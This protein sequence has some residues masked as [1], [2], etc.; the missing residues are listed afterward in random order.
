MELEHNVFYRTHA[1]RLTLHLADL[2]LEIYDLVDRTL[3]QEVDLASVVGAQAVVAGG[4]SRVS[5][6]SSVPHATLKIYNYCYDTGSSLLGSLT[7]GTSLARKYRSCHELIV[8]FQDAALCEAWAAAVNR[9]AWSPTPTPAP[10][11]LPPPRRRNFLVF[12]NPVSGPGYAMSVWKSTVQPMLMHA[13]VDVKL[14]VTQY[15]NHARKLVQAEAPGADVDELGRPLAEFDCIVVVSGDGLIFEVINGIAGRSDGAAVL[16]T[17]PIAAV[18]GGT[19]NGL[20]KSVLFECGDE[21]SATNAVFLALRGAA[22]PLD[23]S[24][25]AAAGGRAYHAF[26]LLGWGLIADVD[27]QSEGLRWMGEARLYAAAIYFAARRRRYRGKLSFYTGPGAAPALPPLGT[28]LDTSGVGWTV[29]D[30][31]FLLVWVLQTSHCSMSMYSGPGA[32]LDDGLF[33][34]FVVED[35]NQLEL[36]QL[37]VDMDSGGHARSA[38]VRTIKCGAYRIE[39]LADDGDALAETGES[40]GGGGGAGDL[41]LDGERIPRGPIQGMVLPGAARVMKTARQRI[42]EL[43]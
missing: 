17:L 32:A 11:S 35:M 33:T 34:V 37:L 29:L 3:V 9:I 20:A 40:G 4:S 14:V 2:S 36:L 38:K 31:S 28:P 12:V 5:S 18:P 21:C 10:P 25:V 6:S 30:G 1:C 15:A 8:E 22:A 27:L 23:V 43:S 7:C 42:H 13:G 26:L 24:R 19:S 39:P 16:A 41:T